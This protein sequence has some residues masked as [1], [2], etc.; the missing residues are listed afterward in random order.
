MAHEDVCANITISDDL[1]MSEG[2]LHASSFMGPCGFLL[3]WLDVC[4]EN[5]N[6]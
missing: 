6:G 2:E 1:V 5:D 3:T 4:E